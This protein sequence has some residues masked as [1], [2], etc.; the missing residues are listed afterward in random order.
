MLQSETGK[1]LS[2]HVFL[3]K[4]IRPIKE[5]AMSKEAR[6]ELGDQKQPRGRKRLLL[7]HVP[8]GSSSQVLL[9]LSVSWVTDGAATIEGQ[10]VT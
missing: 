5:A 3:F 9:T 1:S 4:T 8:L 2:S 6:A 10:D 7:T